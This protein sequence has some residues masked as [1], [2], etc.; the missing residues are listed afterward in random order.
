M[1]NQLPEQARNELS[2][3]SKLIAIDLVFPELLISIMLNEP[4]Q[5]YK[6][7]SII[8]HHANQI[9]PEWSRDET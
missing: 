4:D 9:H 8:A 5:A 6:W 2:I 1:R 3:N 7:A